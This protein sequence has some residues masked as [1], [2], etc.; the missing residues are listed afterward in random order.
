MDQDK[1]GYQDTFEK[2]LA[3][4]QSSYIWNVYKILTQ[5]YIQ[6]ANGMPFKDRLESFKSKVLTPLRQTL[7]LKVQS[8]AKEEKDLN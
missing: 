2:Y 3:Q 7:R 4:L 8:A 5:E 6:K 1:M